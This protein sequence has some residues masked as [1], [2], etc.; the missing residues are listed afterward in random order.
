MD[1]NEKG[2]TGANGAAEESGETSREIL[3]VLLRICDH[4]E[5]ARRQAFHDHL[6]TSVQ[7][8]M[9]IG[10]LLA[11]ISHLSQITG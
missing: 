7:L 11:I 1:Q 6:F 3:G 5:G 8:A 9:I 4:L 10:L 2:R